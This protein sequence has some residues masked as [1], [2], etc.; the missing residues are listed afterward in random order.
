MVPTVDSTTAISTYK[1]QFRYS[2]TDITSSQSNTGILLMEV[3][4]EFSQWLRPSAL[5]MVVMV[6]GVVTWA[7]MVVTWEATVASAWVVVL[8]IMVLEAGALAM[9]CDLEA[10]KEALVEA[11]DQAKKYSSLVMAAAWEAGVVAA[12]E[13]DRARLLNG[14]IASLAVAGVLLDASKYPSCIPSIRSWR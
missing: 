5:V 4:N 9:E 8:A 2:T 12:S 1:S 13:E 14:A 3:T 11:W 7:A 10:G 6:I